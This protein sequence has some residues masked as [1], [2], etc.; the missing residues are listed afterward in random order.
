MDLSYN[1]GVGYTEPL[2]NLLQEFGCKETTLLKERFDAPEEEKFN[3][4]YAKI[5]EKQK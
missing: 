3:L 2:G 5:R 4:E 1:P